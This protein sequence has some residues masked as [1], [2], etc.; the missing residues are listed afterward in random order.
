MQGANLVDQ[1]TLPEGNKQIFIMSENL[2]DTMKE[3]LAWGTYVLLRNTNTISVLISVGDVLCI[4]GYWST[5]ED[6]TKTH[7][8]DWFGRQVQQI[9]LSDLKDTLYFPQRPDSGVWE[10]LPK[11]I[12]SFLVQPVLRACKLG[13]NGTEKTIQGF[14]LL[15][16][17]M[18]YAYNN[19]DRDWIGAV[20]NK[21][22]GSACIDL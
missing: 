22:R 3:D 18:S 4:R 12:R 5:P 17:S 13:G 8:L 6:A 1:S 16:S 7:M 20:A 14:I 19:R 9:G 11:G 2:S 10:M 21:F 15:A